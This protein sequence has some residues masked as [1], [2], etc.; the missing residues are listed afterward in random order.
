VLVL[1]AAVLAL[2]C[3]VLVLFNRGPAAADDERTAA[4]EAHAAELSRQ[5]DLI[6]ERAA[7]F[8]A[9]AIAAR[10]QLAQAMRADIARKQASARQAAAP[11]EPFPTLDPPPQTPSQAESIDL[12]TARAG[13]AR[14]VITDPETGLFSEVFF[15]ASLA[16]RI[17]ASRRGLRPL[18]V[19]VAEVITGI[20]TPAVAPAPVAPVAETMVSVFREADT[21][22]RG[23]GSLMLV[24]LEDTPENGAI[25]TLE[26]L[27][28]RLAEDHDGFTL[29]VGLSCYPAYG[30]DADQLMR[31]AYEALDAAREWH[32]DRIE[33][34]TS[35]PDD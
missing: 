23:P 27:R 26:R 25:W 6:A 3:L 12:S 15:E 1:I 9:E 2:L 5:Q 13:G 8:E 35:S 18:S 11:P 30:F 20:G 29:R 14:D 34:T 31:Q 17:S 28:R 4:L 33:V 19:A 10:A 7:R 21:L 16:K 22:A 32:Q 24:L